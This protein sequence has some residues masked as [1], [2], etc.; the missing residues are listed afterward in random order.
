MPIP[1]FVADLRARIGT[2]MLWLP[3][4]SGVVVDERGHLLLGRRADTGA[5]AVVSGILEP[6][7]E[8]GVAIVREAREETGVDV[9]VVALTAVSVSERVRYPNGDEAQYLD[10]CFWC[11]P[12][13]GEAHVADDESLEVGWFAPGALPEPLT[14][15]SRERI[16]RTLAYI[17]ARAEGAAPDPWFAR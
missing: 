15:S 17:A 7:E 8:P 16:D 11:R 6:G 12:V 13:A 14:P 3:G 10:T 9:E 2:D 5:W 1:D 4:V